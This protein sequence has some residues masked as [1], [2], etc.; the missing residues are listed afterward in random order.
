[1]TVKYSKLLTVT[2]AI[3]RE[4][5]TIH[6]ELIEAEGFQGV[7]VESLEG[8]YNSASEFDKAYKNLGNP[9]KIRNFLPL[10]P[11]GARELM[12][13]L[14]EALKTAHESRVTSNNGLRET[15]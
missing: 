13:T 3:S 15:S 11:H 1:M 10:T 2:G 9:V 14:S 6:V 12:G 7:S 8:E 5:V 4:P